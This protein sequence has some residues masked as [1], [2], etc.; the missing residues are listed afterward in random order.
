MMILNKCLELGC[1]VI[2]DDMQL[3][4]VA[5]LTQTLNDTQDTAEVLGFIT[6]G[7]DME[8]PFLV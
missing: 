8:D 3:E 6:Q 7:R 4:I 2:V 1:I 5:L